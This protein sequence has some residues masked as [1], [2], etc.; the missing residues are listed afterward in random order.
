MEDDEIIVDNLIGDNN[1]TF[2][3][4]YD[5]HGGRETV[6]FVVKTL[7]SNLTNVLTKNSD[8]A[9]LDAMTEAY[10]L[11]DGQLRR[12]NILRSG[13]TAVTCVV[14]EEGTGGKKTLYTGNVGDSR[15]VL[16]RAGKAM[17][18]TID[19]KATLPEEEERITAA[20]GFIARNRVNGVLAIS[21]ALGDHMLKENDVVS[22]RPYVTETALQEDDHFLLLACDGVWDVMTDQEA[23]DFVASKIQ[24]LDMRMGGDEPDQESD[25]AQE[26]H[27]KLEATCKALVREAL[28]RRSLDNITCMVVLLN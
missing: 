11:T 8:A 17:R 12:K 7:H 16:C 6:D 1:H 27:D 21:R 22:A 26:L 3:G 9:M 4:L 14:R 5:G 10:L 19:H 23:T 18:L 28:D 2:F 15:A 20:G 24:A 25:P 13:T